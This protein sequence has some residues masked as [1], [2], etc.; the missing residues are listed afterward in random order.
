MTDTRLHYFKKDLEFF[1]TEHEKHNQ[2]LLRYDEVITDKVS[3]QAFLVYKTDISAICDEMHLNANE[4]R[5]RVN[6]IQGS[7]EKIL[8]L[9]ADIMETVIETIDQLHIDL[10]A[11]TKKF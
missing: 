4:I 11:D 7:N 6:G 3:K 5:T 9:K 8:D 1:F 2:I 10:K